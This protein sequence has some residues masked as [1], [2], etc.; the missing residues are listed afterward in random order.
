MLLATALG[1]ASCGSGSVEVIGA[2]P[3]EPATI[4]AESTRWD[5]AIVDDTGRSLTVDFVAGGNGSLTE[6]CN[7]DYEAEVEETAEEILITVYRRELVDP[8]DEGHACSAI[9]Y[10]WGLEVVLAEP[11]GGR[12]VVDGHDSSLH[13]PML[14][15]S[16][17]TGT[18]AVLESPPTTR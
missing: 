8:P 11:L 15:S 1:F 7:A 9:G 6:P 12:T 2:G 5:R 10:L 16:S 4:R 17:N 14:R 18:G 13:V 3:D